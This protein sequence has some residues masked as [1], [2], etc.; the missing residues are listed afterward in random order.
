M[1]G[2][3]DDAVVVLIAAASPAE[4]E[5]LARHLVEQR[6][7]ACVQQMAV[8]ST[9][10][11]NGT[12]ERADEV[13]LL[14][15]SRAALFPALEQAVLALHSYDVPEIVCLPVSTGHRPYLDWLSAETDWDR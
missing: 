12:V 6:L 10:R 4:A 3:V 15:K 5:V 14:A 2:T 1:S 9:Y 13:L 7:A 11:W 8:N